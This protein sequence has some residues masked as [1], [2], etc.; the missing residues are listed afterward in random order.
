MTLRLPF[1]LAAGF[2]FATAPLAAPVP[3]DSALPDKMTFRLGYFSRELTPIAD[4]SLPSKVSFRIGLIAGNLYGKVNSPVLV[5]YLLTVGEP[6]TLDLATM[7]PTIERLAVPLTD[8]ATRDGLVVIPRETRLARL[9]TVVAH[10]NT[11]KG[12]GAASFRGSPPS[13]T[14]VIVYFDRPCKVSGS[15]RGPTATVSYD[16]TIEKRGV[17]MLRIVRDSP[18]AARV[19][20]AARPVQLV[21]GVVPRR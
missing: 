7:K 6:S 12:V 13:E 19:T 16:V 11:E 8:S 18:E 3:T 1:S 2:V 15:V 9:S 17:Y 5:Q 14:L 20:M 21:L 4:P 10:P